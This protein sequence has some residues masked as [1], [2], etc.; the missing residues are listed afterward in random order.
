MTTNL[1]IQGWLTTGQRRCSFGA[2]CSREGAEMAGPGD[3]TA[4]D[5]G[6]HGRLR[7]SHADREQT[8]DTLKTAFVH[9]RLD[10]DE[11]DARIGLWGARSLR[12]L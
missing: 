8:I 10:K 12:G 3:Q 5:A 7:A 4:A 1:K 6:G 9:G 11:F 2:S